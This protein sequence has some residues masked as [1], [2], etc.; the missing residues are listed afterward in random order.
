MKEKMN[1]ILPEP[2]LTSILH[3]CCICDINDIC[4]QM[5]DAM[6]LIPYRRNEN[7]SIGSNDISIRFAD[8][9]VEFW[10][11]IRII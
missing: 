7:N 3:E 5:G 9:I 8:M 1:E 2:F 6:R 4:N 11:R 10:R